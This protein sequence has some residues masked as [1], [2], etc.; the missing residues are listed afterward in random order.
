MLDQDL[1]RRGSAE[2]TR[3]AYAGDVERFARWCTAHG[4]GDPAAVD[5]RTVRRYTQTLT[6]RG[7]AA[8]SV[9]RALAALRAA[10]RAL[11]RAGIVEGNP[12]ELAPGPRRPQHL[13]R[14]VKPDDAAK[15]LDQIP[16]DDDALALRDRAMLEVAYGCGLRAAELVR[17]DVTDVDLEGRALRTT[18]KGEKTRT[19]PLGDPAADAIRRYLARGR[20][21]LAVAPDTGAA[22]PALLLSR[23]GRRLSTSDVRR[24]MDLWV[25][26]AGL[27]SDLHPHA[28]RHSFA[29]HLL[30]GGADL[31]S[32]QELL[33]HARLSTTQ[34]YT[35]VES[36]RLKTAYRRSH[37]RA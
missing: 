37:P 2:R 32:I 34:V 21:A 35:R 14:V 3:R 4:V 15:L 20:P 11:V 7:A 36:S 10:F 5:V 27:P 18:G 29:T 23:R 33:G 16:A 13:P 1:A 19:V 30:D 6:E 9:T 8:S 24:R 12:A 25:R 26:A 28:L 22:E 31:R 17:I